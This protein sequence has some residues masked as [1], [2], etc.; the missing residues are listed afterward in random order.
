MRPKLN[1]IICYS[2]L[3]YIF[4]GF[5]ASAV[6]SIQKLA[7]VSVI[8]GWLFLILKFK[9]SLIIPKLY[10]PILIFFSYIIVSS[11]WSPSFSVLS[12][13]SIFT[14]IMSALLIV[15]SLQNKV[16]SHTKLLKLLLVPGV[17]N[18]I[19]YFFGVNIELIGHDGIE[20]PKE[21]SMDRFGGLTGHPNALAIRAI[22]PL[23]FFGIFYKEVEFKKLFFAVVITIAI[24]SIIAT[25]SK[26]AIILTLIGFYLV[27]LNWKYGKT[28]LN[29]SFLAIL[30][31]LFI[32]IPSFD[33][34]VLIN[35]DITAL[36][37]LGN[38]LNGQDESTAERLY[39]QIVA[40]K[41]FFDN[42]I[43]GAG[44]NGFAYYSGIGAYAHNNYLELAASGGVTGLL[45][46]YIPFV[47]ILY[48][49]G[50]L[51]G[52]YWFIGISCLFTF[53]ELTSVIYMDRA[54]TMLLLL[55]FHLV[56]QGLKK[57]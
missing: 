2:I 51:H 35:S 40:P 29:V 11:F 6:L 24:F 7:I 26:K 28:I 39:M 33:V 9:R 36:E 45:M 13:A 43:F 55:L 18:L 5:A 10:F 1:S 25:G 12:M 23:L 27:A 8:L 14:V 31:I 53:V 4:F 54:N 20:V 41:I 50:R 19:C 22:I 16:I 52:I 42:F 46:Y 32:I 57:N 30:L 34:E 56:N 37:R 15:I 48:L 3:G 21:N 47:I 49:G 44:L 38:M 17:V